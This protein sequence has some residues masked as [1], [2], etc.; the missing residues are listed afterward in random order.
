[1]NLSPRTALLA[2]LVAP[3]ALAAACGGNVVVDTAGTTTTGAGG[4]GGAPGSTSTS[5]VGVTSSVAASTGSSSVT[6]SSVVVGSASSVAA[7]TSASGTSSSGTLTGQCTQG[8]D[9]SAFQNPNLE[10]LLAMCAQ[11]TTEDLNAT[12]TCVEDGTN[13]SRGCLTC[14][15]DGVAC[16]ETSC[17]SACSFADTG[18]AGCIACRAAQCDPAFT[19]CSGMPPPGEH[20]CA[21]TLSNNPGVTPPVAGLLPSQFTT[22]AA[23]ASYENLAS[24]ACALGPGPC[25]NVCTGNY[26]AGGAATSPC[27]ACLTT[28]CESQILL[29]KAN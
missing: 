14:L 8:A 6:S 1:M 10:A 24:C 20:T 25:A 13:V 3:A 4:S 12:A 15:I 18:S 5:V 29:C 22:S 9:P 21:G 16:T 17:A 28:M 19:A 2:L 11:A 26:C 7:S 27:S 23:S